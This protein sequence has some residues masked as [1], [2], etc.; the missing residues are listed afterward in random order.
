MA[1]IRTIKPE[2]WTDEKIMKVSIPARLFF[3]GL[4]N[5]AD[6]LGCLWY[7]PDRISMQIFPRNPELNVADLVQELM[8]WGILD[9][10]INESSKPYIVIH[11]FLT[12]QKVDHPTPSKIYDKKS[13]KILKIP[14]ELNNVENSIPN[15]FANPREPSLLKGMEGNGREWKGME[16]KTDVRGKSSRFTPP[17]LSELEIYCSERKNGVDPQ[18]FLDFYESKGWLIG[19]NKM[20][21]WKAA[22]R[23]WERS[24]SGSGY[25][26][27]KNQEKPPINDSRAIPNE[28]KRLFSAVRV[29]KDLPKDLHGWDEAHYY[30]EGPAAQ[31]LLE[32]CGGDVMLAGRYIIDKGS[33]MKELGLNWTL[34][35]ILRHAYDSED[36][37]AKKENKNAERKQEQMGVNPISGGNANK[38][39]PR[40][41]E[42]EGTRSKSAEE[43]R[44]R[45]NAL[46]SGVV[47]KL[48]I[49]DRP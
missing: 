2:F 1:R 44:N 29:A 17:T 47:G 42:P 11:N 40:G 26:D 6:D 21:D 49:P 7:S 46:V 3:I 10:M 12:H 31:K 45:L 8:D 39:N 33:D 25:L 5:F 23:T 15:Y 19:K 38:E 20:K 34:E 14:T 13:K 37:A 4:W 24:N 28:I 27:S 35:T 48:P 9:M 43:N 36:L 41:G 18:K 30:K 32:F 22:V 16:W